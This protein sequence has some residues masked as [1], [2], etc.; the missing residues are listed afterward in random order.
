M[1]RHIYTVIYIYISEDQL[2]NVFYIDCYILFH[3]ITLFLLHISLNCNKRLKPVYHFNNLEF[4]IMIKTIKYL[5]L[6]LLLFVK[7]N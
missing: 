4:N 7:M 1:Y 5:K 2:C 6:A 3:Q